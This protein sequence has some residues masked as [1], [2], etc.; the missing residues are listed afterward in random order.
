MYYA[1]GMNR[2]LYKLLD[3]R[4]LPSI[5]NSTITPLMAMLDELESLTPIDVNL[6][7]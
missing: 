7:A 5:T 4:R 6:M 3:I 1:W 2:I